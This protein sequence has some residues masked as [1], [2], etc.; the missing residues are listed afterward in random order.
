MNREKHEYKNKFSNPW[1]AAGLGY[2]DSVIEPSSTRYV[3]GN[4]LELLKNKVAVVTNKKH[5]NIPL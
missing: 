5:G 2:I 1:V 3:L 4:S